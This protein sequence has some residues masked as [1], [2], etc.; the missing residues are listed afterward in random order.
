MGLKPI[1]FHLFFSFLVQLPFGVFGKSKQRQIAIVVSV[2]TVM[3][4]TNPVPFLLPSV[5]NICLATQATMFKIFGCF[6]L[7]CSPF[8]IFGE[9]KHRTIIILSTVVT[10]VGWTNGACISFSSAWRIRL[11]GQTAKFQFVS[12]EFANGRYREGNRR[13]RSSDL[14]EVWAAELF[15]FFFLGGGLS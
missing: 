2:V 6:S 9:S 8:A 11:A 4:R 12:R 15:F 5:W 7:L 13:P 3:R 10:V 1:E 14:N